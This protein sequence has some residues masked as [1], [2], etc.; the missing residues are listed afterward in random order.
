MKSELPMIQPAQLALCN[1]QDKVQEWIAYKGIVYN[2]T[3]FRLW[4]QGKNYE[5][6]TGRALPM[7][8][9]TLRTPKRCLKDLQGLDAYPE[10][11]CECIQLP[12]LTD[13]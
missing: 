11:I 13:L 5:H 12:E 3:R 9:V 6:W 10:F 2:L 1:G 7:N 4:R 8:S